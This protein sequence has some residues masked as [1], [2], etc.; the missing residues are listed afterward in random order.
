MK[1][2]YFSNSAKSIKSLIGLFAFVVVSCG[3]YQ[4]S[5]YYDRDG[6]Y[7]ESASADSSR[8]KSESSQTNQYKDYFGSLQNDNVEIFTDVDSYNT[9]DQPSGEGYSNGYSGWGSESDHVTVNVY[10]NNWGYNYWNTYWYG[11]YWGWNSWYTPSWGIGWSTYPYYG[12]YWNSY[13]APYYASYYNYYGNHYYPHYYVH[14][15][16]RR[17]ASYNGGLRGENTTRYVPTR[18]ATTNGVRTYNNG[19]PR[20]TYSTT[21]RTSTPRIES[22]G[23]PRSSQQNNG[24]RSQSTPTRSYSPNVNSGGSRSGGSYGGGTRSGGGRR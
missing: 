4:N 17:N 18:R 8:A 16:R 21:P 7:G 1:T 23:T 15:P 11:P 6:I 9:S 24:V 14:Q 19:T 22:T 5:S 20:S 13:Y 2:K 12:G 3:S 10:G